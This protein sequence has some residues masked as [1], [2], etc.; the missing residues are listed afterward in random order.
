MLTLMAFARGRHIGKTF[1]MMF[2]VIA[3]AF[4]MVPGLS[5][6]PFVPTVMHLVALVLGAMGVAPQSV[7]TIDGKDDTQ[8]TSSNGV[9]ITAALMTFTS[10]LG[11]LWFALNTTNTLS[12]TLAKPPVTRQAEPPKL[13]ELKQ[14][15]S[16]QTAPA[17]NKTAGREPISKNERVTSKPSREGASPSAASQAKSELQKS[18]P[19]KN[20]RYINLND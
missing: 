14:N 11:G 12:S 8:K 7:A 19:P 6:V 3:A 1:I 4:D 13:Q 10:I 18:E 9:A 2:P 16:A 5:L 20:S 15:P 17:T